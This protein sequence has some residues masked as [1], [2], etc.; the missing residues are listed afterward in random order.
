MK[1]TAELGGGAIRFI[2]PQEGRDETRHTTV[3]GIVSLTNFT[4]AVEGIPGH[5]EATFPITTAHEIGGVWVQNDFE[6]TTIAPISAQDAGYREAED[7]AAQS[8]PAL[9]RLLADALQAEIDAATDRRN[10]PGS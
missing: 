4:E 1:V 3:Q 5:Y 6:L 8:L 10:Q 2:P 7:M 9:L